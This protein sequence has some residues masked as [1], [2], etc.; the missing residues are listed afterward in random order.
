M[1][2]TLEKVWSG[3]GNEVGKSNTFT[4]FGSKIQGCA[5]N[6]IIIIIIIFTL[7]FISSKNNDLFMEKI[8]E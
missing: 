1:E 2:R 3:S 4:L 7:V 5:L 8:L 6:H